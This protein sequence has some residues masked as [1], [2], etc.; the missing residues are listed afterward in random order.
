[1]ASW[2]IQENGVHSLENHGNQVACLKPCRNS[3]CGSGVG[4]IWLSSFGTEG[5]TG[6]A[7]KKSSVLR[8]IGRG[9]WQMDFTGF[10]KDISG[11]SLAS[12]QGLGQIEV[13]QGDFDR[14]QI[15]TFWLE[16]G[17]I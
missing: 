2:D 16:R 1:M 5:S 7:E 15:D 9:N 10:N 8:N 3:V 4:E 11:F 12:S 14:V 6:I 13:S 17:C